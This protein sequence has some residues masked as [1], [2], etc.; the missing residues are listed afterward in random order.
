[1]EE[2]KFTYEDKE[3]FITPVKAKTVTDAQKVYNKAFREAIENGALLRKKLDSYMRDQK[4]WDDQREEE[5]SNMI[6]EIADLEYNL[7]SGGIKLSDAKRDALR[8]RSL[9]ETLKDLISE[10]SYMDANTAE[11]QADNERFNYLVS[12]CVMDYLTRKPVYSYEKY[13]E[14]I[15]TDFAIKCAQKFAHYMYGLDENYDD[16]LPENKFLKRFKFVDE[17][18]RLVDKNR[19]LIDEK[20]NLIDEEGYRVNENEERVDIN[21]RLLLTTTVDDVEFENDLE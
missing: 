5:Y 11:G 15:N 19:H 13:I 18:S 10:R 3:Y 6:K 14:E 2:V 17:K 21:G 9:R 4:L 12:A 8:L 1:M 16:T 20:G 7:N